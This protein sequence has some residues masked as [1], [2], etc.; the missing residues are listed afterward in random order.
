MN[1]PSKLIFLLTLAALPAGQANAVLLQEFL[2]ND[3]AGTGIVAT[4]NSAPGGDPWYDDLQGD[5]AGLATNGLGQY[6]TALKSNLNTGDAFIDVMPDVTGGP[7]YGVMELSY[8]FDPL[9][10][11]SA[12]PEEI[13]LAMLSAATAGSSTIAAE[14]LIV[15]TSATELS[16]SGTAVGTGSMP[17]PAVTLPGGLTAA[18]PLI[19]VLSANLDAATYTISFSTDAG[20][21]FTTLAGGKMDP[22][23][24]FLQVRMRLNNDLSQDNVLID[25]VAFSTDNPFPGKIPTI[26]EPTTAVLALVCVGAIA[27]GRRRGVRR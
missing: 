1:R 24:N 18:T 15:R 10:Y 19:A 22:A 20:V 9:I 6:S 2:F 13:R 7:V 25:R 26:P 5:L 12:E 17:I 23:R 11:D 21:S 14:F 8:A 3:P 27:A 16:F 4:F